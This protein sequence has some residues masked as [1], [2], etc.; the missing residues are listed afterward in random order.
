MVLYPILTL[1]KN[2]FSVRNFLG[3]RRSDV[4]GR[5]RRRK[6][7]WRRKRPWTFLLP[8]PLL[9]SWASMATSTTTRSSSVAAEATKPEVTQGPPSPISSSSSWWREREGGEGRGGGGEGEG[10]GALYLY[11][12]G[13]GESKKCL[14]MPK[15]R[16]LSF[17]SNRFLP[18]I[19]VSSKSIVSKDLVFLQSLVKLRRRRKMLFKKNTR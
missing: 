15:R 14:K 1:L 16:Q 12:S 4:F 13:G 17:C 2:W 6:R 19:S 18:H 5:G 11:Y 8:P 7:R 10:R 9:H 3:S